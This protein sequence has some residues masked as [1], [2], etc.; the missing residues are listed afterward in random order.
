VRYRATGKLI[1][2]L[3]LPDLTLFDQ[4][5]LIKNG[6]RELP[7]ARDGKLLAVSD[8]FYYLMLDVEQAKVLWKRPIDANDMTRE[9]P[10]RFVLGGDFFAVLKQDYDVK[11]IYMLSSRTGDVLWKTDPKVAGSPQPAYSMRIR[12]GKLYGFHL[13]PGLGFYFVGLDCRTGKALFGRNEQAGYAGKP[14][15]RLRSAF[16][17]STA[18]AEVKDRQTFELR[19]FDLESG[20]QLHEMSVKSA[21]DFGQHGRVSAAVQNGR[22]LLLGK[23]ALVIGR[24]K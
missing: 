22:L 19:A 10:L 20:K 11:A 21:G 13:H 4:H 5:P 8:G 1:A 3:A 15:V 17:G 6:P 24:G 12:E 7:V 2:R 16:Y 14:E 9:P 23:N 18:V